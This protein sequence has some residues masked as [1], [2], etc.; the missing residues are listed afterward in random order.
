MLLPDRSPKRD[1]LAALSL[2]DDIELQ[3]Y[4]YT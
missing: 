3:Q 2:G 1:D 4:E